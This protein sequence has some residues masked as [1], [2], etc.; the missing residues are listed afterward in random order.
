[1]ELKHCSTLAQGAGV[2]ITAPPL[3]GANQGPE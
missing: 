1:M 2:L 3:I